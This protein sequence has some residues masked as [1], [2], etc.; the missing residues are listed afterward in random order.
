M[1]RIEALV[2]FKTGN[3]CQGIV[4]RR[5]WCWRFLKVEGSAG[6]SAIMMEGQTGQRTEAP[7]IIWVPKANVDFIQ[8]VVRVSP[9]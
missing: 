3:A 9:A 4:S 7:G 2:Q 5:L 6:N 1:K 8:E